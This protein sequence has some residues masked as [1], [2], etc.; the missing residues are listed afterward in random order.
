M[1][2]FGSKKNQINNLK[3]PPP[4][5]PKWAI[6]R[7]NLFPRF[8]ELDPTSARLEGVSGVFAIWHTGKRPGWVYIGYSD[9]LAD[10]LYEQKEN[11]EV[12]FWEAR[13]DLFVSW[14]MI[15]KELQHG[16]TTYLNLLLKPHIPNP[17]V[18]PYGTPL[19]QLDIQLIPVYPPGINPKHMNTKIAEETPAEIQNSS[20][21][22]NAEPVV[23]KPKPAS[24]E[25]SLAP[26][27]FFLNEDASETEEQ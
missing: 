3:L 22:E 2:L 8:L 23:E 11:K 10:A 25:P 20:E 13:G 27:S 16:A 18:A 15:K 4:G 6:G 12:T 24:R 26:S 1:A 19:D 17:N 9:N 14:C 7:G 5:D 21:S